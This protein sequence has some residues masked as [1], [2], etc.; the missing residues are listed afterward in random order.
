VETAAHQTP[1]RAVGAAEPRVTVP[2]E[3]RVAFG[4]T[5]TAAPTSDAEARGVRQKPSSRLVK[6][7]TFKFCDTP[8]R[9]VFNWLTDQTGMPVINNYELKGTF[10][11]VPPRPGKSYT[12][13]EV[14]DILNEELVS[15]NLLLLCGERFLVIVPFDDKQTD[16]RVS[17]VEPEDLKEYPKR[18]VVGV[19]IQLHSLKAEQIV[20]EIEQM[21]SPVGRVVAV[22]STNQLFLKDKVG[23]LRHIHPLLKDREKQKNK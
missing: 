18:S 9:T 14:I 1:G 4:V 15:Q 20:C 2:L 21:L 13:L 16:D 7:D 11:F 6:P 23:I 12:V 5:P 10:S 19:T 8:W 17:P 22:E 3:R